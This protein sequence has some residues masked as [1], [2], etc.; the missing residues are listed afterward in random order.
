[1]AGGCGA[2][3][4]V[5]GTLWRVACHWPRAWRGAGRGAWGMGWGLG[6]RVRCVVVR[7]WWCVVVRVSCVGGSRAMCGGS[8]WCVV[9]RES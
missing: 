7:A 6:D 8:A 1:M 4:V 3:D 2:E 9:A 5:C